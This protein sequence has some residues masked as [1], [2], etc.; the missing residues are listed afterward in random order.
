MYH[1][2]SSSIFQ[3]CL[4]TINDLLSPQGGFIRDWKIISFCGNINEYL[5]VIQNISQTFKT[6]EE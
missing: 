5:Q 3:L 1:I 2:F 4:F 6:K